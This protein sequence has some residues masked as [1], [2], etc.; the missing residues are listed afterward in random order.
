M[1]RKLIALALLLCAV[2]TLGQTPHRIVTTTRLVAI[3]FQNEDEWQRAIQQK[4][5]ATLQRLMSEDFQVWTP[6]PPGEP[7]PREQWLQHAMAEKLGTFRIRQM[8]ARAVNN[9]TVVVSFVLS[10]TVEEA[11]KT[12]ARDYFIVDLWQKKDE[13]W[14]VTDR[15]L[16]QINVRFGMQQGDVKPTGKN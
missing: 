9:T 2:T 12:H 14:Q 1:T 5:Q 3:F 15:Y 13:N 8:A 16:S 4:D 11:G 10:E 7:I 6:A